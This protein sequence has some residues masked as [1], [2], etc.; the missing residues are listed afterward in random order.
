[1]GEETGQGDETRKGEENT[2]P[3]SG[4]PRR[5]Q[6]TFGV[7]GGRLPAEA[8]GADGSDDCRLGAKAASEGVR[9]ESACSMAR[10]STRRGMVPGRSTSRSPL[11]YRSRPGPPVL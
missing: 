10:G 7:I 4:S 5:R 11:G 8:E 9:L 1:M 6:Q 2:T 3:P